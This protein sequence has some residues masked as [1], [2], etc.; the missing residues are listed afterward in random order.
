MLQAVDARIKSGHDDAR[1]RPCGYGIMAKRTM[2]AFGERCL[3]PAD[4][5]PPETIRALRLRE[6]AGQ[7]VLARHLNATTS[8]VS[9]W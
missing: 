9:Q 3:T 5:M 1:N 4:D 7:A 6:N 2:R 8:R